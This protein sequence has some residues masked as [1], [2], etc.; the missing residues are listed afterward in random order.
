M[1]K[2]VVRVPAAYHFDHPWIS[3]ALCFA[4]F[5]VEETDEVAECNGRL[6]IES[7]RLSLY[8]WFPIIYVGCDFPTEAYLFRLMLV[9]FT[10]E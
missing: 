8:K 9:S 5:V 2:G 10:Q 7:L 6:G 4:V 3:V 1:P